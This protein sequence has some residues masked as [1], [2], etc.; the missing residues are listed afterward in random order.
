MEMQSLAV[1]MQLLL[2]PRCGPYLRVWVVSLSAEIGHVKC[3]TRKM[4]TDRDLKLPYVRKTENGT[5]AHH[6][7]K[8]MMFWVHLLRFPSNLDEIGHVKCKTRKM[9]TDRD[10]KLPYARKKNCVKTITMGTPKSEE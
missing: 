2:S 1:A 6:D 5:A 10:L 9:R 4:R 8:M 3:K 7:T